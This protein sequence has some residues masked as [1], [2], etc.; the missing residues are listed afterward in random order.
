MF[1]DVDECVEKLDSCDETSETCRNTAG[2]Y[3]CDIQCG[4][5]YRYDTRLRSCQGEFKLMK[6]LKDLI[7]NKKF[8]D[9]DIL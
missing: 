1:V 3:E 9:S 2:A 7:D 4:E 8:N 6:D 5:G